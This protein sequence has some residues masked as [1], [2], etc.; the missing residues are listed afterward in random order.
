MARATKNKVKTDP[1]VK[2]EQPCQEQETGPR[3]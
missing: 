1:Q 3:R 2:S